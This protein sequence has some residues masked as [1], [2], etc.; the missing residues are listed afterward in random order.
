MLR[1]HKESVP[2]DDQ[3]PCRSVKREEDVILFPFDQSLSFRTSEVFSFCKHLGLRVINWEHSV[4][5]LTQQFVQIPSY[6]GI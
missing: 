5:C 3:G 6:L 2:E 4:Q 1:T